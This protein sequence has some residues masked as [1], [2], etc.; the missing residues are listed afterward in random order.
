MDT[1][2]RQRLIEGERIGLRYALAIPQA[3]LTGLTGGHLGKGAGSSVDFQDYREYEPGDDLRRIDWNV[4]A[5]SDRLT[6]KLYR[7]EVNPHLDLIIDGSRSMNL[8]Q[9]RKAESVATL[10]AVLSTAAS[11]AHC[12]TS[13][14]LAAD[15]CQRVLNDQLRP[16]SWDGLEFDGITS[17]EESMRILPPRFR[18]QSVRVL[19][20]DLFWMGNPLP[21]LRR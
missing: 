5:R 14:W 2:L 15:G 21:T 12:S 18:R 8:E 17:L 4:Y 10:A 11:N 9:T 13:V 1:R 20:S 6:V 19:L 16:S 7:E 3:S